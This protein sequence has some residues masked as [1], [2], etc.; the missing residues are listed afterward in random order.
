M[1]NTI[2]PES[3][4]ILH[5]Y[6]KKCEIPLNSNTPPK[7]NKPLWNKSLS[8]RLINPCKCGNN[9]AILKPNKTH[10]AG[11]YC[12]RCGKYIGWLSSDPQR[13]KLVDLGDR[14]ELLAKPAVQTSL[15]DGGLN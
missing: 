4:P 11:I 5:I 6:Y 13:S 1:L 3:V 2:V 12:D 9:R 8:Y 14:Q 7:P 10:S 15:F